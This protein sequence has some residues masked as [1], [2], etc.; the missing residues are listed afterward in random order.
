M[1]S[2]SVSNRSL[3]AKRVLIVSQFHNS[4]YRILRLWVSLFPVALKNHN[5]LF[6]TL[7]ASI[8]KI[9][10]NESQEAAMNR[11]HFIESEPSARQCQLFMPLP[12]TGLSD[13]HDPV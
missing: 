10:Y 4:A 7:F 8:N 6:S 12:G 13:T 1:H 3:G 9:N 5:P 11:L 2:N